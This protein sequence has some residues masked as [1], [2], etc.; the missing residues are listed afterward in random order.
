MVTGMVTNS[1][2]LERNGGIE[3]DEPS[4]KLKQINTTHD[5]EGQNKTRFGGFRDR[6]GRGTRPGEKASY[7]G[8]PARSHPPARQFL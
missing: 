6:R 7:P 3:Q 4:Q 1:R 5:N 2:D 8:D